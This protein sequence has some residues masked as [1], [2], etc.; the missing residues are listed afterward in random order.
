MAKLL[1]FAIDH[2]DVV[3]ELPLCVTEK[4]YQEPTRNYLF[5][6]PNETD[7]E[8]HKVQES[9]MKHKKILELL[10][11]DNTPRKKLKLDSP[12]QSPSSPFSSLS[13]FKRKKKSKFRTEETPIFN[14][15]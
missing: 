2:W 6:D 9:P 8:N 15:N 11:G 10:D 14:G 5:Q 7:K 4:L 1:S 13:P 12:I 3:F